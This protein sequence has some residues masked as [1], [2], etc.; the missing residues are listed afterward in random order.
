MITDFIVG[1]IQF[2]NKNEYKISQEQISRFFS[3]IYSLKISFTNEKDIIDLM[4]TV[5]CSTKIQSEYIQKYFKEYTDIYLKEI[6]NNKSKKEL[7]QKKENE[8]KKFNSNI[9]NKETFLK[10]L[11]NEINEKILEIKN[12]TVDYQKIMTNKDKQFV[13]KNLEKLKEINHD[14]QN[15]Q[16]FLNEFE[17]DED[18]FAISSIF[19]KESKN[20][21]K[22]AEDLLFNEKINDFQLE[23]EFY[24]ISKRLKKKIDNSDIESRI[25]KETKDLEFKKKK[26]NKEIEKEK[27]KHKQIINQ[28]DQIIKDY[29]LDSDIQSKII[30]KE[31]SLN[32][33]ETFIGGKNFIQTDEYT[34]H[35]LTK[36]IGSLN[37][38]ERKQIIRYIKRNLLKLK[39]KMNRNIHTNEKLSLSM[40]DTIQNACKTGGLPIQLIFD[41]PINNK[42]NLVLVLDVSGSCSTASKMMLTFM[43][44]LK[45]VFPRGCDTFAFVNALYDISDIMKTSNIETAID[46]VLNAIPRKGVYSNYYIPLKTLWTEH[47][48]KITKDSVVIFMGDARNNKNDTAEEYMKNI[49]HLAKKCYWLNTEK[50]DEWDKADSLATLYGKYSTMYEVIN[51]MELIGFIENM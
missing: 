36:N 13:N 43:Y 22:K 12:E 17:K 2:L 50:Y 21:I 41:K 40:K 23:E 6:L 44:L 32:H 51:T 25:Q 42:S 10:R 48:K 35:L 19:E 16:K 24:Q 14:N 37:E 11:D 27:Q 49:G 4:K 31:T 15:I 8:D 46:S 5:F 26:V 34:Q 33:R 39:T 30:K 3:L 28:I 7:E 20:L 1:F 45:D 9:K 29:I 18:C 47:R 38:E